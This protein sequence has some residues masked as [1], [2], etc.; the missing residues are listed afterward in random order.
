M[1][2][3]RKIAL[4]AAAAIAVLGAGGA[5]NA[6]RVV[7]GI[8]RGWHPWHERVVYRPGWYGP[9]WYGDPGPHYGYYG[10]RGAYYRNCGW[11]GYRRRHWRCR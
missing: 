2:A 3:G 4:T 10:W 11:R 8:G 7:I 1:K 6:Q 5:A 9:V